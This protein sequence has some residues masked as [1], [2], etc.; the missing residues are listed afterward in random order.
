MFH[1]PSYCTP[2]VKPTPKVCGGLILFAG[3]L[4]YLKSLAAPF[5]FDDRLSILEDARIRRRCPPTDI[6]NDT[7]R[8]VT[9]WSLALND[10]VGGLHVWGYHAVNL[11]IHLVAALL[12]FGIVRRTRWSGSWRER[13][14][15]SADALALVVALCWAMHPLQTQSVTYISQRAESLA[16]LCALLTLYGVIRVALPEAFAYVVMLNVDTVVDR[17]WLSALVHAAD[18]H[19]D[20]HIWQSRI[21]LHGMTKVNSLGNRI[22]YLGFGYCHGYGQP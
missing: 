14:G 20:I 9:E 11:L 2:A 5:L 6:L 12:L 13:D 4:V 1:A 22:H 3:L 8:L 7:M 16:G 19:S 17:E 15:A 10:A 18:E 21:L